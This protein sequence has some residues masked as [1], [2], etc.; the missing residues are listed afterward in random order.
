MTERVV[1]LLEEILEKTPPPPP[2]RE[3]EQLLAEAQS[4]VDARRPLIEALSRENTHG[5]NDD[6]IHELL[7]L[8]RQRDRHWTGV[9]RAA[10][11]QVADRL[12]GMRRLGREG[13]RGAATGG[14]YEV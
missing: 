12:D 11:G 2:T 13:P 9:L 14:G 8:L 1:Q 6:R 4:L 5:R 7:E 3:A 10:R